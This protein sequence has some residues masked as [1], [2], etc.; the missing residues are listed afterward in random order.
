MEDI[1]NDSQSAARTLELVSDT[2]STEQLAK[3]SGSNATKESAGGRIETELRV[4]IGGDL[5]VDLIEIAKPLT[6]LKSIPQ[7]QDGGSTVASRFLPR[8]AGFPKSCKNQVVADALPTSPL[9][10]GLA[11]NLG[12]GLAGCAFRRRD[13]PLHPTAA[14]IHEAGPGRE[15]KHRLLRP[16]ALASDP[17]CAPLR[18]KDSR[19]CRAD[20]LALSALDGSGYFR[21]NLKIGRL[22][23]KS[24]LG[25]SAQILRG[26]S[27][28]LV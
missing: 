23:R 28:C 17:R 4:R 26:L 8:N 19:P 3:S 18:R 2:K 15:A 21:L 13:A 14:K 9:F 5:M 1:P 10:V 12:K 7:S 6:R 11:R 25:I 22:K 20:P 24:S 27:R 16:I